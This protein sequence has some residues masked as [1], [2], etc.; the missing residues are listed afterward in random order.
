MNWRS[1]IFTIGLISWL[2]DIPVRSP[3]SNLGVKLNATALA[4]SAPLSQQQVC[5][6]AKQITVKVISGNGAGSGILIYR[7]GTTYKVATNAHVVRKK[8]NKVQTPDGKRHQIEYVRTLDKEDQ[9]GDD[10][11]IIQFKSTNNYPVANQ[12][13]EALTS[14]KEGEDEVIAAG[15]PFDPNTSVSG[16]FECTNPGRISHVLPR[17]MNLG[18]QVGYR[19]DIKKGM[20]GGPLLNMQG[21]VVGIN[22]LHSYPLWGGNDSSQYTFKDDTPVNLPTEELISSSWAIPIETFAQQTQVSRFTISV[23]SGRVS[24]PQETRENQQVP[25]TSTPQSNPNPPENKPTPTTSPSG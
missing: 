21:E 7:Q 12:L 17:P 22:G 11:A 6:K 5:Q 23:A 20:S 4:Q 13:R 8:D 16:N 3:A 15:F 14:L 18:Y 25:P 19:I 2:I 24:L 9:T 1:L 10:L